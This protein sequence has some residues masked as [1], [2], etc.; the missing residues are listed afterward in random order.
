MKKKVLSAVLSAVMVI[1]M[2]AGCGAPAAESGGSDDAKKTEKSEGIAKEDIKVGFVHIS[3]PSDMGYTYN[4][5][6]GT[7]EMQKELG[8][9]DEQI[10]NKYNV[11]EGAECDTALRELVD[12]GCNIIFATSFGYE[13]YVKEVAAEY[14]DIEFCH[15]TGLQAKEAGLDNFHNYFASIYEGR[16]LAGIAAGM[17]TESNKLG[18]VAAFPFAE[19]ISG[20]TA[21]YLGAKSVNPDVTMD[22]MY[23][24]SWNDPT[25][26]SQV[27][28]ALIERGCDVVSQHSDSTAP[29][30]TAEENG[31]WQVG[32]NNDMIEAAPD[33]SLISPRIDWGIY[34][35]EAVQAVIDGKEIP[36]D[37]CKGY[38]DGAVYLSPLNEKIAAEGTQEAIDKAA[39]AIES[40]ELHVFAGP[41]KGVTPDGEEY[42]V[43][44]GEYYHEQEEQ[45]APSWLY[46]IDGCN[47][48]E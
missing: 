30:T 39:A 21:F 14:P 26:E 4:H 46:I 33:A 34:V 47:V 6:L 48:V 32:Y 5:D 28:K 16:Y 9:S 42:E 27:A 13:D 1:G 38:K 17:K 22:I 44:E 29:A 11:P 18:Y 45:S 19:V 35:T 3:D 8:L 31:V 23:T 37:W 24:N 2:V 10:V 7:Q 20:Y 43:K 15:A 40:G 41:L 36:L 12:A 25:V